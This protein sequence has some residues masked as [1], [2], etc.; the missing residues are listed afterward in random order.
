MIMN[1]D[2]DRI[3]IGRLTTLGNDCLEAAIFNI[4]ILKA[5]WQN[6]KIGETFHSTMPSLALL[7]LSNS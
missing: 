2:Q 7:T 3:H 4:R 1:N 6:D 5:L